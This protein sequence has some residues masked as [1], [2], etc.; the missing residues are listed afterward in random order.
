MLILEPYDATRVVDDQSTDAGLEL[1]THS[2]P[3][4]D[5]S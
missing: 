3:D 1:K 2:L 5:L 4:R